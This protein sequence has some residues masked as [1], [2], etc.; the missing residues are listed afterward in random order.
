M[1]LTIA[2]LFASEY[3]LAQQD[4]K[5]NFRYEN[6]RTTPWAA[7][8]FRARFKDIL[9]S[10]SGLWNTSYAPIVGV[11]SGG[12]NTISPYSS[13]N[14]TWIVALD[15]TEKGL[16]FHTSLGGS[17]FFL[18]DALDVANFSAAPSNTLFPSAT[19]FA[20]RLGDATVPFGWL[21]N[22][23]YLMAEDTFRTSFNFG[24]IS[25]SAFSSIKVTLA[26]TGTPSVT[27]TDA[28]LNLTLWSS[29]SGFITTANV[30]L[31]GGSFSS[32]SDSLTGPSERI[33]GLGAVEYYRQLYVPSTA[34]P[35]WNNNVVVGVSG[36]LG[37]VPVAS[38]QDFSIFITARP[39]V[40]QGHG[41]GD[42]HLM[43][44]DGKVFDLQSFGKVI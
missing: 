38:G 24:T 25:R 35:W 11:S 40:G 30:A 28:N 19:S 20:N 21:G 39:T 27:D 9:F 1:P 33:V 14:D 18:W 17:N 44:H 31:Y 15:S 26:W 5:D 41:W 7:A 37:S 36:S 4:N 13:A 16:L 42:V 43:S 32:G 6:V 10:S 3:L 12:P 22:P 8:A 23:Y 29:S 34:F 2:N